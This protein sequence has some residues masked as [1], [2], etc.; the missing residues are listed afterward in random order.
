MSTKNISPTLRHA[1]RPL[2]SFDAANRTTAALFVIFVRYLAHTMPAI[3]SFVYV[4]DPS[5]MK[6]HQ[7]NKADRVTTLP[8]NLP[9][10]IPAYTS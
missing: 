2:Y 3:N 1:A 10:D 6:V 9:A 4:Y 7:F 5:P 8:R